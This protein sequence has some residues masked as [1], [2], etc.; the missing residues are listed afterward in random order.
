MSLSSMT[1]GYM[2]RDSRV[3]DCGMRLAVSKQLDDH[4]GHGCPGQSDES[5]AQDVVPLATSGEAESMEAE[6][7]MAEREQPVSTDVASHASVEGT[8]ALL[9]AEDEAMGVDDEGDSGSTRD[10]HAVEHGAPL[11]PLAAVM[12]VDATVQGSVEPAVAGLAAAVQLS[13]APSTVPCVPEAPSLLAVPASPP[14]A[15]VAAARG[16]SSPAAAALRVEPPVLLALSASSSAAAAN[17]PQPLGCLLGPAVSAPSAPMVSHALLMGC[18]QPQDICG[19]LGDDLA[20]LSR[21]CAV[22]AEGAS[23]EQP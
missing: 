12:A 19:M 20:P 1:T 17:V 23:A 13:A 14:S 2:V 10:C 18:L 11:E 16:P 22:E 5:A 6:V 8:A 15:V 4:A 7:E 21:P 9:A 3:G